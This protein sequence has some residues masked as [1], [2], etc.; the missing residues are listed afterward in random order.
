MVAICGYLSVNVIRQ[1][2]QLFSCTS[3]ISRAQQPHV[4]NGYPCGQAQIQNLPI[5]IVSSIGSA[6]LREFLCFPCSPTK[7]PYTQVVLGTMISYIAMCLQL[8]SPYP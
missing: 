5:F 1:K 6:E 3:R 4:S 8:E 7:P 2:F